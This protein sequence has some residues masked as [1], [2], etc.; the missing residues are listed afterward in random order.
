[1]GHDQL[2]KEFLRAFF[3]DFLELFCPDIAVRLNFGTVRFWKKSFSRIS[4]R[5]ASAK[6]T[7]WPRSTR[8]MVS[9]G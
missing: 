5:V 7:W 2:F 4:R 3:R 8:K 6:R 1:M 9:K